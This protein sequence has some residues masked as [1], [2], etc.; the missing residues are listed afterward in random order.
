MI[1]K[2]MLKNVKLNQPP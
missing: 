1:T 2:E